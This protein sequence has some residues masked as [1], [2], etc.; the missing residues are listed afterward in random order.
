MKTRSAFC[1]A[2]AILLLLP[3]FA[4]SPQGE[5]EPKQAVSDILLEAYTLP[6]AEAVELLGG[7]EKIREERGGFITY[8][9]TATWCGIEMDTEYVFKHGTPYVFQAEKTYDVSED[10]ETLARECVALFKEQLG[11]P[12]ACEFLT[13]EMD[14]AT[15]FG[16]YIED[17]KEKEVEDQGFATV[18]SDEPS[19]H[20]LSFRFV[21]P[22]DDESM[23]RVFLQCA[24]ARSAEDPEQVTFTF[25]TIPDITNPA[26][27]G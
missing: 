9:S 12:S 25:Q 20:P 8:R 14:G 6:E 27:H 18:F 24:F 17:G 5:N 21:F 4:C 2:L 19:G 26:Y 15:S 22:S 23:D 7:P 13:P 10:T 3:L 1:L 16:T 11:N